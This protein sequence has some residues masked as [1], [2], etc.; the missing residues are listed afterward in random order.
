M[1]ISD[2]SSDVCS[3]DLTPSSPCATMA[4]PAWASMEE[5]S[6]NLPALLEANTTLVILY[7]LF[8]CRGI[9]DQ[10][11]H[12][13]FGKYRQAVE[14]IGRAS[15]RESMCPYV[16]VSVVAGSFKQKITQRSKT[17]N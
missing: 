9:F 8:A 14:Q 12:Q 2:W 13:F 5:N 7:V 3:S 11:G 17:N 1:R 6:F 16:Q 10:Q 15:G 4:M